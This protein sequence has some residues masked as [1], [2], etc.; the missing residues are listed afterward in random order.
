MCCIGPSA[1]ETGQGSPKTSKNG[2]G[3]KDFADRHHGKDRKNQQEDEYDEDWVSS[4]SEDHGH[5]SG[6]VD[7][8]PRSSYQGGTSSIYKGR[9]EEGMGAWFPAYDAHDELV[10]RQSSAELL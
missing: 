5:A 8:R 10:D 7:S 3:R 1:R 4:G 6:C 2:C 9:W